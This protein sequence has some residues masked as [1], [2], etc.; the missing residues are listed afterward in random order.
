MP[1]SGQEEQNQA[2]CVSNANL[3]TWQLMAAHWKHTW[4][5]GVLPVANEVG[6]GPAHA[7][8]VTIR[9]S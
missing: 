4:V 5:S 2:T 3:A 7:M 6:L 9:G 1:Q 8:P